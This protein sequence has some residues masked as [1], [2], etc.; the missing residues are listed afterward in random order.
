MS[1]CV[2]VPCKILEMKCGITTFFHQHKGLCLASGTNSLINSLLEH[3][4]VNTPFNFLCGFNKQCIKPCQALAV[5]DTPFLAPLWQH[6]SA[7]ICSL[8]YVICLLGTRTS[9]HYASFTSIKS[10]ACRVVQ[11]AWQVPYLNAKWWTLLLYFSA[12]S[13]Y[14]TTPSGSAMLAMP[15]TS[16]VGYTSVSN[17]QW[18]CLQR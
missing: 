7:A 13:R 3:K 10:F 6:F 15:T 1:V 12:V 11:T 16:N 18:V 5:Q 17:N 14:E 9:Y 4:V 2:S 8:Q